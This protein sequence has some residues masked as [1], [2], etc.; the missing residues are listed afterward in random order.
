MTGQAPPDHPSPAPALP[1]HGKWKWVDR[2]PWGRQFISWRLYVRNPVRLPGFVPADASEKARR[3]LRSIYTAELKNLGRPGPLTQAVMVL[4]WAG[5]TAG[6][7]LI[8]FLRH[9]PDIRRAFPGLGDFVHL[10]RLLVSAFLNNIAPGEF[11]QFKFYLDPL[12]ARRRSYLLRWQLTTL[13]AE[14]MPTDGAVELKDKHH[15]WRTLSAAGIPTVPVRALVREGRWVEGS[16]EAL[17][18][19]GGDLVIKPTR[20]SR[21]DGIEFLDALGGDRWL[22]AG[23]PATGAAVRTH[24]EKRSES[25]PMILQ[26]LM[27]NHPALAR[28]SAQ[29]LIN[30]RIV[31]M[32]NP[33]RPDPVCLVAALRIPS[34]H[35]RLAGLYQ[36]SS[37]TA[38]D[39]DTGILGCTAGAQPGQEQL[40]APPGTSVPPAGEK[41][42]HWEEYKALCLAGHRLVPSLNSIGWD[43]VLLE[44]GPRLLEANL[45]WGAHIVQMAGARPLLETRFAELYELPG[46]A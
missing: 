14:A 38:I 29:G 5:I 16:W 7:C 22:L 27:R 2:A 25:H 24:I 35:S 43:V 30:L 4:G 3:M 8:N 1:S 36:G 40:Q 10:R 42:P 28:Y 17:A 23:Q 15:L 39:V 41:L 13:L 34:A 26:P 11:Y 45:L 31:T 33:R 12:Y 21:G 19:E 20:M 32:K 46:G 6:T 18:A 9:R 37:I 44:D